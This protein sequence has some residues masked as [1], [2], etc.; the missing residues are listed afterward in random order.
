MQELL[1]QDHIV[2]NIK[3]HA[4]GCHS[5]QFI[6]L[7]IHSGTCTSVTVMIAHS[8][9]VQKSECRPES[10]WCFFHLFDAP[11]RNST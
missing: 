5:V 1:S 6:T 2:S 9:R 7:F 11:C 4:F 8:T 10:A 3:D